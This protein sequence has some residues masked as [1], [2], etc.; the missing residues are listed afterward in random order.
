MLIH[1]CILLHTTVVHNTTVLIIYHLIFQTLIIV[2]MLS[3]GTCLCQSHKT[4]VT[5]H[6]LLF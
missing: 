3:T 1:D 2:H 6:N 5:Q 4:T